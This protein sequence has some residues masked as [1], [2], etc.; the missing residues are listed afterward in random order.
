MPSC[1]PCV[2]H[3]IGFVLFPPFG[4]PQWDQDDHANLMFITMCFCWH[5]L[6]ALCIVAA[7]YSLVRWYVPE[8]SAKV[9]LPSRAPAPFLMPGTLA[10]LNAESSANRGSLRSERLATAALDDEWG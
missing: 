5:Y 6:A 7:N 4:S 3:Q 9:L 2:P 1:L 10:Q 8:T